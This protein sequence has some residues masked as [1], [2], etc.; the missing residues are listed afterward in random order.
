MSDDVRV[1][2]FEQSSMQVA[3]VAASPIFPT[4]ESANFFSGEMNFSSNGTTVVRMFL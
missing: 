2:N 3:T 1:V 4:D